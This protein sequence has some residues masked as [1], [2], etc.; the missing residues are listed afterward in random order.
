M[1]DKIMTATE[2]LERMAKD[3]KPMSGGIS[4]LLILQ[5]A[6]AAERAASSLEREGGCGPIVY[7][8]RELAK[9][10][11]REAAGSRRVS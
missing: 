9:E 4:R 2:I 3:T 10:L 7:G 1:S 8:L 11:M 6:R 5:M